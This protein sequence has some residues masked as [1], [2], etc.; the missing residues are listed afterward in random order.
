MITETA[1]KVR[2]QIARQRIS[3]MREQIDTIL[4]KIIKEYTESEDTK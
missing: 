2:I 1:N 3:D 4:S